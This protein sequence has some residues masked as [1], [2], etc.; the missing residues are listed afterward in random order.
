MEK[1][2]AKQ[3]LP[4]DL[5]EELQKYIQ[6]EYLY[7]PK[8]D[9]SRKKWGEHSGARQELTERNAQIRKDFKNGSSIN[10]LSDKYFLSVDRIKKIVYAKVTPL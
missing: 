5:L 7:I 8:A 2:N 10:E 9:G 4:E 3:I 6:G 1:K